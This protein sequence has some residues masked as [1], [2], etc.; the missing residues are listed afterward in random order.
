MKGLF[1]AGKHTSPHLI[2][3]GV[4]ECIMSEKDLI[5]LSLSNIENADSFEVLASAS[6]CQIKI[7]CCFFSVYKVF[8]PYIVLFISI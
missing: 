5:D 8:C 7:V 4:Q 1:P 3:F 6:M 2:V